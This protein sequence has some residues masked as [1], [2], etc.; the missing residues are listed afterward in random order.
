MNFSKPLLVSWR[1]RGIS[2]LAYLFKNTEIERETINRFIKHF[3]NNLNHKAM[4]TYDRIKAEGIEQGIEKG[5][6]LKEHEFIKNL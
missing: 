3:P 1:L 5:V 2:L 4:S 6:E